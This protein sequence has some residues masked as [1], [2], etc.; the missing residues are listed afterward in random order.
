M[1]NMLIYTLSSCDRCKRLLNFLDRKGVSYANFVCESESV[2]CDEV[3]R[4]VSCSS[5]PIVKVTLQN[6]VI[7]LC[8]KNKAK[9]LNIGNGDIE[10]YSDIDSLMSRVSQIIK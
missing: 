8:I 4:I 1:S 3:E 2:M 7:F 5:Y 6:R 10:Y 9:N